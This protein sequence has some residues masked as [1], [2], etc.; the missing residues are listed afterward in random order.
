MW[1]QD[2]A[3]GSLHSVIEVAPQIAWTDNS[4][5]HSSRNLDPA[6]GGYLS[7]GPLFGELKTFQVSGT[8]LGDTTTGFTETTVFRIGKG[9]GT[10]V[11]GP[12]HYQ[13]EGVLGSWPFNLGGS[14]PNPKLL[15]YVTDGAFTYYIA[16]FDEHLV[17]VG[18]VG[19]FKIHNAGTV[20]KFNHATHLVEWQTQPFSVG[21][22]PFD[23]HHNAVCL[24][25][26]SSGLAVGL[27]PNSAP[28][29]NYGVC[30]LDYSDGTEMWGAELDP[31][32]TT[33]GGWNRGASIATDGNNILVGSPAHGPALH[34]NIYCFDSGG[35]LNWSALAHYPSL[36][37]ILAAPTAPVMGV[38]AVDS[39]GTDWYI[40]GRRL[41]PNG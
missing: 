13:S 38:R 21:S 18:G 6:T 40:A 41:A 30:M 35:S 34:S 14:N 20:I 39:D 25:M 22:Q 8:Y 15:V 12:K 9:A 31:T 1:W 37:A 11:S 10:Y 32:P 19:T 29:G 27:S 17:K 7:S 4:V 36:P 2:N 28:P 23:S 16:P 33:T 5:L 24:A 26:T 3:R